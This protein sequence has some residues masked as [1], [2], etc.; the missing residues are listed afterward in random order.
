MRL[1]AELFTP[2]EARVH[3]MVQLF[4]DFLRAVVEVRRDRAEEL[5]EQ[6]ERLDSKARLHWYQ[7]KRANAVANALINI[8]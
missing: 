8:G 2:S 3:R 6:A 7:A 4:S 1:L 5:E